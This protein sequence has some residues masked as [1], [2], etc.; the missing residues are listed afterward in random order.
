MIH[1]DEDVYIS[2]RN[3]V[4]IKTPDKQLWMAIHHHRFGVDGYLF[5]AAECPDEETM[6]RKLEIN[7]EP[8]RDEYIDVSTVVEQH[9]V[10]F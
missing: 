6:V 1:E 10:E 3:E 8:D 5:R 4:H 2:R 9:I 7:Y